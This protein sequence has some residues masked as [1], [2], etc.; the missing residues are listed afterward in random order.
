MYGWLQN[1]VAKKGEGLN[2]LQE[3]LYILR[4]LPSLYTV[5]VNNIFLFVLFEN[6]GGPLRFCFNHARS[7]DFEE[8]IE[9]L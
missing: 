7:T 4:V 3:N 9:G 6:I 5:V 1:A 8:K 2:F